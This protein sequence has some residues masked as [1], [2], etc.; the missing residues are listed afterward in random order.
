[1]VSPP[2][3]TSRAWSGHPLWL[4]GFR[5]FFLLACL[6]GATLPIA[7]VLVLSG[8][9][10]LPPGLSPMAWHAHEMFYGFGLAVL[11]GFLLTATKNWVQVRGHYGHTLQLLAA[12]WV[13]ERFGMWF[14]ASWPL[15][16]RLVSQH[17]YGVLL[18]GLLVLTL[19]K[20]RKTD[21]YRDNPL[22]LVALPAFLLARALLLDP[23]HFIE[24]RELTLSLFR[25]AFLIML[26]RTSVPFMKAA[27]QV[28]LPRR[29]WLD[30]GI[31]LLG[32]LL[33]GSAWMP[34]PARQALQLLLAALF[35]GRWLTW[36]PQLAFRR[37]EVGVMYAGGL[38]LAV[39]LVLDV[40]PAP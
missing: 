3:S 24:G 31:K 21:S 8:R 13:F 33:L 5:P 34:A 30:H 4:V 2:A 12:A 15:P 6:A 36:S 18:V 7:W 20:H 28:A 11:G 35:V 27:F 40:L 39:Q 29:P 23:A 17:L 37:L 26:E 1:M 25:L 32:L 22:F 16:L 9:L 14:G 10:A 19:V 38:L